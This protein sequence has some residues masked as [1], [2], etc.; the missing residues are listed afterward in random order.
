VILVPYLASDLT[1]AYAA[2]IEVCQ[3]INGSQ[4]YRHDGSLIVLLPVQR[5]ENG[6]YALL[7][8]TRCK[9]YYLDWWEHAAQV[10]PLVASREYSTV[11][12][13]DRHIV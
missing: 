2:V 12:R 3:E 7:R 5:N 9:K 6:S 8:D 4:E 1:R 11:L 10:G 13:P